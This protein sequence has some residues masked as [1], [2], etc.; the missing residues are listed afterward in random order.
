MIE[1]A[2]IRRCVRL[3][4][5]VHELHKQGYQ[6]LV[7]SCPMAPSGTSWRCSLLPFDQVQWDGNMWSELLGEGV[8]PARHSSGHIGNEYFGWTDA[9]SDTARELAE[10]IKLRF[11]RLMARTKRLNFEYSGWFTYMLGEAEQGHL[12]V[13]GRDYQ[14]EYREKLATTTPGVWLKGPPLFSMVRVRG[15]TYH[16]TRPPHLK[17]GDDW[18]EAY[19]RLV[20]MWQEDK[21][22][23]PLPQYP[24]DTGDTF[25]LGAYWEG[26]I[27]YI[28]TIL[29]FTDIRRFLS[30]METLSER[31][32][33][34]DVFFLVWNSEGQLIYLIA[35]LTRRLLAEPQKYLME[36]SER[37]DWEQRLR[38]LE[39]QMNHHWIQSGRPPN[40]YYGGGNPLHLGLILTGLSEDNLVNT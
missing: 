23:C 34:W 30:A 11:P 22:S 12:P 9:K 8:E 16:Y 10:K 38:S 25:E 28:Q 31:P 36:P 40:P 2:L 6:D 33:H 4:G 21:H 19:K 29:G 20:L 32:E 15:K 7:V 17:S 1:D 14:E 13:M 39:C 35:F 37:D 26:A 18:H 27:Y 5:A 3:L 24:I